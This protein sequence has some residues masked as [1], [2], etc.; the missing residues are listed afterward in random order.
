MKHSRLAVALVASLFALSLPV[1][2]L[3][4][5]RPPAEPA[6]APAAID[7]QSLHT[8][9]AP[10]V[11]V[12]PFVVDLARVPTGDPEFQPGVDRFHDQGEPGGDAPDRARFSSPLED[13][14]FEGPGPSP[15]DGGRAADAPSA[16][17][18]PLR[19]F[20]GMTDSGW[21]PPDPVLAV[22]PKYIVEAINSGFSVYTKDGGL[23]RSYT[24]LETF[25][26]PIIA[27]LP[28]W[29]V[30]GFV[31]DP[32]ILYSPE[33]GKYVLLGLAA[34]DIN[35]TSYVF[36]AVSA[37]SNPLGN[38]YQYYYGD[39]AH[40]ANWIDYSGLGSDTWGVYFTGQSFPWAGGFT[41]S[42]IFSIPATVFT[43]GNGG[44]WYFYNLRWNETGNPLVF[45]IQPT[46][47]HTIAGGEET[48]FVNT[49]TS[50][51][52]K[53][54]IWQLTGPR[55]NAP[56]LV[57]NSAT[58]QAYAE[59]GL[60]SQPGAVADDI[61]M[62]YAGVQN[63]AYSQRKVYFAL[64]DFVAADTTGFY[65]SKV[66]VD[67]RVENRNITYATGGIHY[68]YPNV[69]LCGGDSFD[70]E[71]GVAMSWSSNAQY[72]SGAIK[73][74]QDFTVDSSGY[75]WGIAS[76]SATYNRYGSGRNRWGD[77]MGIHRDWSCNT[78]WSVTEF[79]PAL[80]VWR[81]QIGETQ[82][83]TALP[84]QCRLIFDD[85]FERGNR[86]NWSSSVP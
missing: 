14:S 78:L 13:R 52:N 67:T 47:A 35:L 41:S 82:C 60:A 30:N 61:E 71:V 68:Y 20:Q 22:G 58:V 23:E 79:A 64:N 45:D 40:P 42:L 49:F 12:G 55:N 54:C 37:T 31:F 59:P 36:L 74:Y 43:G 7:P 11:A 33:H 6:R 84:Q 18:D 48:F 38:W 66:D 34:D 10:L 86:Q 27:S 62:F 53:A 56:T 65:V 4:A 39:T 44:G 32:R 72:A 8:T 76:G 2:L 24:D 21:Y 57:R 75:F 15:A 80:N 70:P 28:A 50:S 5:D 1:A 25:F 81:T 85:G 63:A 26:N 17:G 19:S 46:I 51:G 9:G 69:S 16:P 83:D 29:S 73:Y 77:Y 3:A